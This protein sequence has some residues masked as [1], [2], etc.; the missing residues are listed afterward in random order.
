MKK[1]ISL[2][3]L[4]VTLGAWG[5]DASAQC[6]K[7]SFVSA[8]PD[9]PDATLIRPSNWN[10]CHDIEDGAIG[11]ADLAFDPAT[12]TE[13]DAHI[14]DSS[15]AHAASAVSANSATLSG[16]ATDVQGVLEELDNTID[17]HIADS[18]A[19]HAAS[20]I[21][22]S[23]AT[24]VG[25]GTDVQ[26]VLEELDDAIADHLADA[27]A[28]H[29]A[30]AISASSATLVGVATDV[31]GVLEELDDAIADHLADTS[32]AHAA[33]A[34]SA[35]SATLV[36]V[37]TTVQAVLEELD[38]A[39]VAAET[40]T[41]N[42]IADASAAHAA[43]AISVSSANLTGTGVDVQTVLEELEDAIDTKIDG[44]GSAS[45]IPRFTDSNTL[46]ASSCTD[47]GAGTISCGNVSGNHYQETFSAA[48]GTHVHNN[49]A[50][51]GDRVLSTGTRTNGQLPVYNSDGVLAS[52]GLIG[53]D[54]SAKVYHNA[55]Q[56]ISNNTTTAVVFNS[57]FFDTETMHSTV[58]DTSRIT[59]TTAAKYFLN[60]TVCF[61]NTDT[62]GVRAG[63][64]RINGT[65]Y[66]D[67]QDIISVATMGIICLKVS[68]LHSASANDYAEVL[69]YQ[70]SGS[71]LNL[72]AND[73]TEGNV[74]VFSAHKVN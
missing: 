69:V 31:Q 68:S 41:S 13:L 47:D 12:Q 57:E 6:I 20:A 66:I 16:T 43:S 56:S 21:S 62:D 2:L 17:N 35:N 65:N 32:G 54:I 40:T 39:I 46:G 55:T 58:S 52:S 14:N 63:F 5:P 36:G 37:G 9:S 72:F 29:A 15:A 42:H 45:A 4:L 34:I 74:V 53:R 70:N 26:A 25:V 59:M 10:A 23:S 1:F 44:S 22:A 38:D 11:I 24:L 8:K 7:H 18:S 3:F 51:S 71:A 49:I 61:D 48:T 60:A 73:D 50:K 33:T 67:R 27:S 64:L 30:S 19:A 28:A